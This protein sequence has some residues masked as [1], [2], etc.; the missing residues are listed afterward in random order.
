[1]AMCF[2]LLMLSSFIM[3]LSIVLVEDIDTDDDNL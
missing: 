3:L 1:M 2:V